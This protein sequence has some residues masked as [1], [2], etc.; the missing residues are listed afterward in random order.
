MKRKARNPLQGQTGSISCSEFLDDDS[1]SFLERMLQGAL[2][3][4]GIF[5]QRL[6]IFLSNR[7]GKC[8]YHGAIYYSLCFKRLWRP[9]YV[10]AHIQAP[11][12]INLGSCLLKRR[13]CRPTLRKKLVK[14]SDCQWKKR[15]L[16]GKYQIL[17]Q[18][19]VYL[20][21]HWTLTYSPRRMD[22]KVLLIQV[23]PLIARWKP[24]A[25]TY[26]R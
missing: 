10:N 18:A 13:V 19:W 20:H 5:G 6:F 12:F 25:C 4:E 11:L 16:C 1:L 26:L 7:S 9:V 22:F 14:W 21:R 3:R 2:V 8:N 24:K 17:T 15:N 23:G